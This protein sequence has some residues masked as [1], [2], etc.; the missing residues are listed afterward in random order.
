MHSLTG[1]CNRGLKERNDE[2]NMY[3]EGLNPKVS[4]GNIDCIHNWGISQCLI[5]SRNLAVFCACPE[6]LLET[7]LKSNELISLVED[8]P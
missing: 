7:K 3:C 2:S 6:N 1:H 8:I 4:E 5:L